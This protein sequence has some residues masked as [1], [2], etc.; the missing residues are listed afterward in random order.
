MTSFAGAV[1]RK[2]AIDN[3]EQFVFQNGNQYFLIDIW[4]AGTITMK[5]KENGWSDTWSL[6][7]PLVKP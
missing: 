7:L 1:M 6:P 3:H 4:E 5:I 2:R